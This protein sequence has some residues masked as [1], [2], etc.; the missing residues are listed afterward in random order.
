MKNY[1]MCLAAI[2]ISC[3]SNGQD[4]L[5]RVVAGYP[6][7]YSEDSVG[8]Y[9]L[10]DALSLQDGQKVKDAKTWTEKRRPELVSLFEGQQFGKMPP[11]PTGMSFNVFD[12]GTE[13]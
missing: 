5:N 13:V 6:V 12:K 1:L 11:R 3:Y 7:N 9:T 2:I 8:T 10:P 4:A